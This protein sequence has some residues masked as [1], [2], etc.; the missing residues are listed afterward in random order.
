MEQE[1]LKQ[2]DDRIQDLVEEV[3]DKPVVRREKKEKPQL[4]P[5]IYSLR[6]DEM[7]EW[8]TANGEKAFRA[9]QIYEWLYEK[10]VKTFEE[11]SNLSKGLRDKCRDGL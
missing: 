4:K 11:M 3:A 6:L 7:K 9:G 2:F 1:K 10:R 8:L 5:S